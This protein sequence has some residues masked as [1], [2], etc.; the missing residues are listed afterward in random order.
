MTKQKE[1]TLDAAEEATMIAETAAVAAQD[2]KD[3]ATTELEVHRVSE[4]VVEVE[5]AYYGLINRVPPHKSK[6]AKGAM[7][8]GY[9]SARWIEGGKEFKLRGNVFVASV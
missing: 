9:T 4:S 3:A 5:G 2:A 6:G 8:G 7:L 1:S